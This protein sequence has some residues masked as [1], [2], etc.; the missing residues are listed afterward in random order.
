MIKIDK[1]FPTPAEDITNPSKYP[2]RAM[3]IGDSFFAPGRRPGT[4]SAPPRL[5]AAGHKF[6]KRTETNGDTTGVRIWRIK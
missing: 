2:W 6:V 5:I 4:I 3:E 1:D